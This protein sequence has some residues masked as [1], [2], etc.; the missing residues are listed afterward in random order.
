MKI[1]GKHPLGS[2]RLYRSLTLWAPLHFRRPGPP[3]TR[4]EVP[5]RPLVPVPVPDRTETDAPMLQTRRTD[6]PR[7]IVWVLLDLSSP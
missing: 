3:P 1:C 2:N 6:A 7:R 4:R 5:K